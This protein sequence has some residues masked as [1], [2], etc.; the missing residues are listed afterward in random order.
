MKIIINL[1]N[2]LLLC[3]L[4]LMFAVPVIAGIEVNQDYWTT[5]ENINFNNEVQCYISDSKLLGENVDV[6]NGIL[7]KASHNSFINCNVLV[8]KQLKNLSARQTKYREKHVI[9]T[10]PLSIMTKSSQDISATVNDNLVPKLLDDDNQNIVMKHSKVSSVINELNDSGTGPFNYFIII[11]LV[12]CI[13]RVIN[14][15]SL[16]NCVFLPE[17]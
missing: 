7:K 9:N 16:Y 13:S 5:Q 15:K 2:K 11:A 6:S 3:V 14:K 4:G 12:I 10:A 17:R 8:A 1:K